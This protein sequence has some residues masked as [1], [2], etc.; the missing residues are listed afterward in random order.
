M[1]VGERHR[2]FTPRVELRS[3]LELLG[4]YALAVAQPVLSVFGKSPETFVQLGAGRWVIVTYTLIVVLVPPLLLWGLEQLV[5]CFSDLYRRWLHIGLIGLGVGLVVVQA[6]GSWMGQL[7]GVLL[8]GAVATVGVSFAY[9]RSAA[10]RTWTAYLSAAALVFAVLFL[11][12]S[13]VSDL[14]F[15]TIPP[16]RMFNRRAPVSPLCSSSSTN[17]RRS[18]C[19]TRRG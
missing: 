13:P 5:D 16:L 19:S 18:P 3:F 4:V 2:N 6:V 10:V 1:T 12:F 15:P 14:V 8:I 7:V 11:G 17:S 9:A